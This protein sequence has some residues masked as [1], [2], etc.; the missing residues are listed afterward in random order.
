MSLGQPYREPDLPAGAKIQTLRK[1]DEK[2]NKLTPDTMVTVINRS[3]ETFVRKWDAEDYALLPYTHDGGTEDRPFVMRMPYGAALLFQRHCVIPGTRNP[4]SNTLAA[5]SYL[6]ILGIDPDDACTPLSDDELRT[7]GHAIEAIERDS[8]APVKV[9]DVKTATRRGI[10]AQAM[11]NS[12]GA[13][14]VEFTK[15]VAAEHMR[16]PDGVSSEIAGEAAEGASAL[17][18]TETVGSRA[19]GRSTRK[20]G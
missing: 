3:R 4:D 9:V 15:E 16:P 5:E 6:G 11:G 13:R 17:R 2:A 7:L 14:G 19:A 18:E 8:S 20:R 1:Q 10:A 12:S